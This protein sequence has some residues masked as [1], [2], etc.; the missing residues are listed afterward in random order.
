M[1]NFD[2]V[3]FDMD[4]V[5]FDSERATMNCWKEIAQQHGLENAEEVYLATLGTNMKKTK[6]IVLSYYGQ[7]FPFEACLRELAKLYFERYGEGRLPVKPGVREL[8]RFLKENH[9]KI[10]LASSTKRSTVIRQ[11]RDAGLLESFDE[12]ITGDMVTRSKPDPDI[13][14]LACS[15][16]GSEPART[17]V[18]EDSYHGI[19]AAHAGGFRPVMVPDLLPADDEMIRLCE[20]VEDSL[21]DV[22]LYLAQ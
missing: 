4:G 22:I 3:I 17:Y 19:Q 9:K 18:I 15:R 7:D 20:S 11:L 10:A 21:N 14:L 1:K 12:I 6:E 16:V 13:F 2:A 8:F 5:I